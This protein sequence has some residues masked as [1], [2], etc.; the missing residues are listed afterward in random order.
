MKTDPVLV[1]KQPTKKIDPFLRDG[2]YALYDKFRVEWLLDHFD[3][4]FPPNLMLNGRYNN[5]IRDMD[6]I[7]DNRSVFDIMLYNSITDFILLQRLVSFIDENRPDIQAKIKPAFNELLEFLLNKENQEKLYQE[8]STGPSMNDIIRPREA[9]LVYFVY[10]GLEFSLMFESHRYSYFGQINKIPKVRLE[11]SIYN[12]L[13][14]IAGYST[15]Q[16]YS[17][18]SDESFIT[19]TP[20]LYPENN[21][22]TLSFLY[23]TDSIRVLT[24]LLDV[25]IDQLNNYLS[26]YNNNKK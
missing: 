18:R 23:L 8:Y 9:K 12:R 16:Y 5:I 6:T 1:W 13:Y 4:K 7:K 17:I 20:R 22:N 26:L 3:E 11:I 2:F 14:D 10:N 24:K 19:K 15:R 25:N 21:L